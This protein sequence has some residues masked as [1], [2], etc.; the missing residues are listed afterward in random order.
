M[1]RCF[2]KLIPNGYTRCLQSLIGIP[3][4]IKQQSSRSSGLQ[5]R[6][7]KKS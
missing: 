1:L 3:K 5:L 2:S 4:L 7:W 6:V